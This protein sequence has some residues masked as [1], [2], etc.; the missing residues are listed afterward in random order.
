M[1][2]IHDFLDLGNKKQFDS[3]R[4]ILSANVLNFCKHVETVSMQFVLTKSKIFLVV[5]DV[6]Q[7]D[8]VLGQVDALTVSTTS[9][10]FIIHVT[11]DSDE[12][13]SCQQNRSDII[14]TILYL[15]TYKIPLSPNDTDKPASSRKV[16]VYLVPDMSLDIY[17]TTD[18][19]FEDGVVLRPGQEH[20]VMVS[21]KEYLEKEKEIMEMKAERRKSTKTIYSFSG[22][23][24]ISIDDFE[25]IK[26]L[27][28]GAHGKVLLCERRNFPGERYALKIIKKQH[29]IDANQFE[30]TLAEKIILSSLNHPF[31]VSL[32]YA[33]QTDEKIYFVMEFMK[34]GELF[35]H[36]R[37]CKSFTEE[38]TKFV[39]ACI[40]LA[41]GHLHNHNFIYRDLKPEN[42]L[43]DDRG[44]AKLT[45]FGLAKH[46]DVADVAFTFCGTPEYLAPE[47]ILDK[48]CNR[49]ADWWSLGILV[50][51]ML[52]GLPPFYSKD[53]QEMYKKTIMDPLK[54]KPRPNISD[55][56]KDFIAGL[57]MKAPSK[58][59]GSAAD[60]L[61]V[62]NHAWFKDINWIKLMDRK[63]TPPFNPNDKDWEKNFDPGFIKE[64]PKDSF[65]SI[66]PELAIE[67]K[68]K[69]KVFDFTLQ[70][71]ESA[72]GKSNSINDDSNPQTDFNA[73]S[74]LAV[75]FNGMLK[76]DLLQQKLV[77]D[78]SPPK[79]KTQTENGG[80]VNGEV[81]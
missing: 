44:F 14:Q 74:S 5:D 1:N 81:Q 25:L 60:N 33:F 50:Y 32:K 29:I 47:V 64:A 46:L 61:E 3:D 27:G 73:V 12:R 19:D 37:R 4:V 79:A 35:Q 17:L 24:P 55:E 75:K 78:P 42:V 49:P 13:F 28:R 63:L 26:T 80:Q 45:D 53:V 68:E 15:M 31:L 56:A 7:R 70:E 38:Q 62:M 71:E 8:I 65:C 43:M 48:G 66:K 59:L 77:E 10:E 34:G 36:L 58:R 6:I 23:K 16:K 40:V 76:E 72:N 2:K 41:L 22:T 54:F 67:L 57:L 30:H 18:D 51:E 20:M 11:E 69:F 39:A 52:Y 21:Y 9:D